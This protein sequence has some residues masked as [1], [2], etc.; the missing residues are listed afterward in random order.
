MSVGIIVI[1]HGKIGEAIIG[2]AEFILDR[3]LDDIHLVPFIQ[4]GAHPTGNRELK[5]VIDECDEGDGVLVLTDLVGASPAN[6]VRGLLPEIRARV[7]SGINLAMLLRVCN[8]RE[9]PL[10]TLAGKA[11]AGGKRAIEVMGT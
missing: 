1:T 10:N 7:V 11:A 4:S 6:L 8:Y 5:V 3:S 9:M 2:A